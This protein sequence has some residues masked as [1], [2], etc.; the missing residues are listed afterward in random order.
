MEITLQLEVDDPDF[1]DKGDDT[2]LTVAG[3]ERLM[4]ALSN[5]GFSVVEGPDAVQEL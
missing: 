1:I 5:A 2:G 3:Y 4:A